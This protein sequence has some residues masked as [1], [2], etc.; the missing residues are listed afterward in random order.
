[1]A[2]SVPATKMSKR[3]A[4]QAATSI[5]AG[6]SKAEVLRPR[7]PGQRWRRV[8]QFCDTNPHDP[9]APPGS[10]LDNARSAL[11]AIDPNKIWSSMG[12]TVEDFNLETVTPALARFDESPLIK[13][14][15]DV[16][17]TAPDRTRT[18]LRQLAW[19]LPELSPLLDEASLHAIREAREVPREDPTRIDDPDLMW[20]TSNLACAELPHL[21]AEEQLELISSLPARMPMFT[22]MRRALK[23]LSGPALEERITDAENQ[24]DGGDALKRVLFF[25]GGALPELTD[26][27]RQSVI[28]ALDSENQDVSILAAELVYRAADPALDGGLLD[29]EA[30]TQRNL[31]S[32]DHSFYHGR[33][34]AAALSRTP[35]SNVL[36]LIHPR[37]LSAVVEGLEAEGLIHFADLTERALERAL[38]R[39]DAEPAV[40]MDPYTASS[41]GGLEVR[42]WAEERTEGAN[43]IDLEGLRDLTEPDGGAK[44]FAE[45]QQLLREAMAAYERE[46]AGQGGVGV[47]APPQVSGLL[48]VVANDPMRARR[49]I[50]KIVATTDQ[51]LLSQVRNLGL[52]ICGAYAPHDGD[53]VAAAF[54][55]LR[56]ARSIWNIR[57]DGIELYE[58]ALFAC[59]NVAQLDSL[60]EAVFLNSFNDQELEGAVHAAESCGAASWLTNFVETEVRRSSVGR[61]ARALTAAGFRLKNDSSDRILNTEWG[62]GF[63]ADVAAFARENYQRDEWARHWMEQAV[64]ARTSVDLWRFAKLAEGVVDRRFAI[65]ARDFP[66]SPHW[67][68]FGQAAIERLGKAAEERSKNRAKSLFGLKA[69]DRDL[70]RVLRDGA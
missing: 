8:E 68:R 13:A 17:A 2:L 70:V 4:A 22:Q 21:S 53:L 56:D 49:W 42:T 62:P 52:A 15:R 41:S 67:Q 47:T 24:G 33:A 40:V 57:V 19:G 3:L 45:R 26:V 64:T 65:W 12:R 63:L 27:T 10:N 39:I 25:A 20:V 9:A 69:P 11:A 50:Q 61:R 31:G 16:I 44:R 46:L 60:R 38:D 51:R 66:S 7:I 6:A 34:V 43:E 29:R 32:S 18:P 28:T 1:M 30:S 48:P 14:L 37:F 58:S 36:E 59:G 35:R 23:P 5:A 54:E 55:R